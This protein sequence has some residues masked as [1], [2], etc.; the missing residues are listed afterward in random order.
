MRPQAPASV[1]V[2]GNSGR[3][4]WPLRSPRAPGG[5]LLTS[6]H[7][8]VA[9][10]D[11][12]A[13]VAGVSAIEPPPSPQPRGLRLGSPP[14]GRGCAVRRSL[15]RPPQGGAGSWTSSCP[16]VNRAQ[17]WAPAHVTPKVPGGRGRGLQ[18]D[19]VPRQDRPGLLPAHCESGTAQA[20]VRPRETDRPSP[21]GGAPGTRS[22][23]D[24]PANGTAEVKFRIRWVA[25]KFL[26]LRT[27]TCLAD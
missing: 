3:A 24:V 5:S 27:R 23:G 21:S 9:T 4:G 22:S 2:R 16:A 1:R 12:G 7:P 20:T 18:G 14:L 13:A 15:T 6:V 25:F 10:T 8:A 17:C 11:S 19:R 26:I